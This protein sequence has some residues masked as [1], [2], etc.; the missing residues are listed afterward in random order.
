MSWVNNK[1]FHATFYLRDIKGNSTSLQ[2]EVES[3][4][5][6]W[7]KDLTIHAYPD[8]AYRV[9]ENGLVLVNPSLKQ[10][11]FDL[12]KISPSIKYSRIKASAAGDSK[13][14]NGQA[15][16]GSVIVNEREGLFLEG[17]K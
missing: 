5:R 3:G 16:R 7:M 6:I 11:S 8:V 4:E 17:E 14:N 9:F 15:V 2:F 1:W 13:T 10:Y 12:T